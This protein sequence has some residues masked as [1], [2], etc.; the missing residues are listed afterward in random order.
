M[1]RTD[2]GVGQL[3]LFIWCGNIAGR[4]DRS[5]RHGGVFVGMNGEFVLNGILSLFR[6]VVLKCVFVRTK[7]AL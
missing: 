2:L 1:E 5:G 4:G 3:E 7:R 6:V